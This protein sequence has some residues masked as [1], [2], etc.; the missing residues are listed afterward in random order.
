M[1]TQIFLNTFKE[2]QLSTFF[3]KQDLKLC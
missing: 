2:S 1:D 3:S